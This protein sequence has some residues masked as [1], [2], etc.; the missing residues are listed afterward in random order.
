[1]VI[2]RAER[3]VNLPRISSG[4]PSLERKE[5]VVQIRQPPARLMG[6]D[7]V[8]AVRAMCEQVLQRGQGGQVVG[9]VSDLQ[10]A[11][12]HIAGKRPKRIT[13]KRLIVWRYDIRTLDAYR[14]RRTMFAPSWPKCGD[15]PAAIAVIKRGATAK[16][17]SY[18]RPSHRLRLQIATTG[19]EAEWRA[20]STTPVAPTWLPTAVLVRENANAAS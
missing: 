10:I 2:I 1:M 4:L 11:N 18:S 9:V 12:K 17:L 16:I 19:L 6:T 5:E 3:C 15:A 14:P 7:S 8:A 13:R 20:V